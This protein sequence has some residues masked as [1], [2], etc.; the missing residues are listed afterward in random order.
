MM[1][2]PLRIEAQ[3][4]PIVII[5]IIIITLLKDVTVLALPSH[6]I[7]NC[8]WNANPVDRKKESSDGGS[9]HR[10]NTSVRQAGMEP[11]TVEL[12]Q[13]DTPHV[14]QTAR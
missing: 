1:S 11:S 13:K 7:R 3:P 8:L 12:E 10:G 6:F 9:A 14:T 2:F 4:D 5:I